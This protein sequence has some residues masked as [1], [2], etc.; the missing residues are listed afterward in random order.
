[1]NFQLIDDRN[2]N[3]PIAS[4]KDARKFKSKLF[5]RRFFRAFAIATLPLYAIPS[6]AYTFPVDL[7]LQV[8]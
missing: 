4:S 1:M 2:N 8:F 3:S 7:A 5:G 6:L